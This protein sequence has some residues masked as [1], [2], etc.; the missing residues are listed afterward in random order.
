MEALKAKGV[1]PHMGNFA[2]RDLYYSGKGYKAKWRRYEEKQTDV[3]IG[4][5]L[6]NDAYQNVFDRALVVC[7]DTGMIPAFEIMRLQFPN[8]PVVCVA[9]PER[10]HH[11][12]IQAKVA[13][14]SVIKVSQVEKALFGA[15]VVSAGNVVARR[16]ARY[17]P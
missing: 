15:Q 3:A 10:S 4:A 9:P 16:P 12:D 11:R 14:V 8:K 17:R 2:K 1:I 5:H 7:V 6:I 13:A